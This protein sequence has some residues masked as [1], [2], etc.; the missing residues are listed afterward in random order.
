MS[1]ECTVVVTPRDRFSTLETC[2]NNVFEKTTGSFEVM[3]SMGGCPKPLQ[4]HLEKTFE[5]RVKF[6]IFPD[7]RNTAQLRNAALEQIRTRLT[8]FIDSDVYVRP[9]WLE[10]MLQCQKETGAALVTPLVQDRN[11]R[12]HTGGNRFYRFREKG[13]NY[14]QMELCYAGLPATP[15][16]N[17]ER[18]AAD[19]TEIHCQLFVTEDAR[20]LRVY[21]ERIREAHEMDS[22]LT[23]MKAGKLQMFEPKARVYLYYTDLIGDP[24]DAKLHVWKW[25]PKAI[26]ESFEIF[27]EKWGMDPD[28][29]GQFT[30]YLSIVNHRVGPLTKRFPSRF[31]IQVDRILRFVMQKIEKMV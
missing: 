18:M 22:G 30:H 17:L 15:D 1:L 5:G 2:L 11:N 25:D 31:S 9:G 27:Y 6:L 16:N 13:R 14:V 12:I 20:N 3:L 8:A 7:Y 26:R 24:E 21:E 19:F 28:Y 29:R 10:N 4:R 23:L